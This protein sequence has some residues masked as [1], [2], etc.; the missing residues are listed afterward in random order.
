FFDADMIRAWRQQYTLGTAGS[1]PAMNLIAAEEPA[2]IIQAARKGWGLFDPLLQ[3]QIEQQGWN[4]NPQTREAMAALG[5]PGRDLQARFAALQEGICQCG[6][7]RKYDLGLG[8]M[9]L[10]ARGEIKPG[11]K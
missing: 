3:R 11:E 9:A 2:S 8:A 4:E 1:S 6:A 10:T 5:L 7:H